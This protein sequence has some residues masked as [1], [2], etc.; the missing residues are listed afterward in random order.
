MPSDTSYRWA[1]RNGVM[2]GTRN[3]R[4]TI[5]VNIGSP[6]PNNPRAAASLTVAKL[7][8]W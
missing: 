2:P 8:P 4:D 6:T 5:P 7:H 3:D 1:H